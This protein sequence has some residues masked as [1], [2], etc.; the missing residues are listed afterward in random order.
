MVKCEEEAALF[1]FL[2]GTIVGLVP[3]INSMGAFS[4]FSN[5]RCLQILDDKS[6]ATAK[7]EQA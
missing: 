5:P 3:I 2:T 7:A 6:R 1:F 4:K